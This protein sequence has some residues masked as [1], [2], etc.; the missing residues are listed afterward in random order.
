MSS[1]KINFA[2]ANIKENN[3]MSYSNR[4]EEIHK[5]LNAN[6]NKKDGFVGWLGLPN[7]SNK[8][9]MDKIK[10]CANEIR[11]KV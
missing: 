5:E 6:A 2:N 8:R 10:K 9:E 3:I 7:R 1:F 4:I 11:R